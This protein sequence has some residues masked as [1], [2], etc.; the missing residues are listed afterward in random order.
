MVLTIGIRLRALK[1]D[2]AS[3]GDA[4]GTMKREL[5]AGRRT[6]RL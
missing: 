4:G 5:Y 2:D 3:F 1:M 6:N